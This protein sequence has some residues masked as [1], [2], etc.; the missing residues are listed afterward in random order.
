LASGVSADRLSSVISLSSS[1]AGLLA[2]A[3]F[4]L[5]FCFMAFLYRPKPY[6]FNCH[7]S[8]TACKENE[9]AGRQGIHAILF[10]FQRRGMKP[11]LLA[12]IA[13]LSSV[14]LIT[15]FLPVL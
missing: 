5:S 2:A 9:S 11:A 8:K 4:A 1:R 10:T 14:D 3:G 6:K 7:E 15:T 13:L 12:S